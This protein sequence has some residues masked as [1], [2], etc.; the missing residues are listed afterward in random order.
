M[1]QLAML[2]E[3]SR[4]HPRVAIYFGVAAKTLLLALTR[5]DDALTNRGGCLFSALAGDVPILNSRDFDVQIDAIQQR[6]GD[7]LAITLHLGRTATA[8]AFQIAKVA[9]WTRIHSRHEHEFRGKSHAACSPGNRNLPVLK[10]LAHYFE[11]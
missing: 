2:L 9:A 7:A 11:G 8:F 4:G 6:A 10:W 1:A 3:M 5:A